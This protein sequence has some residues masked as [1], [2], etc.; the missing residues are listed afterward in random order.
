[1]RNLQLTSYYCSLLKLIYV[2]QSF[3]KI[4]TG[5]KG[6]NK[7]R[8]RERERES[9]HYTNWEKLKPFL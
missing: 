6:R 8:G 5:K 2:I 9:Q 1:M 7:G 4:F 3:I